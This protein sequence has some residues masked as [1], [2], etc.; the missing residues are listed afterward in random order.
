VSSDD[1]PNASSRRSTRRGDAGPSPLVTV[2][3][4][5]FSPGGDLQ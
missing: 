5:R 3:W 4:R 1:V 2:I